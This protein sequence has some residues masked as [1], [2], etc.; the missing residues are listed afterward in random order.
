MSISP[1]SEARGLKRLPCL[2]QYN[3]LKQENRLTLGLHTA[4]NI[5]CMKKKFEVKVVENSISYKKFTGTYVYLRQSETK[6]FER[7]SYLKYYNTETGKQIDFSDN[8]T[9]VLLAG[10]AVLPILPLAKFNFDILVLWK[11]PYCILL[12]SVMPVDTAQKKDDE[13]WLIGN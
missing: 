13:I 11:D 7:L 9:S 1:Q 5:D 12:L 8:L 10:P 6:G 3:I 4:K 2:K